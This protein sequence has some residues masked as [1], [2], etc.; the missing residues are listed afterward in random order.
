MAAAEYEVG[1]YLHRA[2]HKLDAVPHFQEAQRLDP[3]NWSYSRNAFA[4]VDR[5]EMGNPYGT[6]LLDEV[7]RVGPETF[8]PE[9]N[10]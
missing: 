8:Y 3:Q 1:Q 2:G 7:A 5:E 10:I 6:D 4:I 9:L